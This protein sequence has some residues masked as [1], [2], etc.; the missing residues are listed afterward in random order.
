MA[1]NKTA[2][3]A[4]AGAT[5]TTTMPNGKTLRLGEGQVYETADPAE[6]EHLSSASGVKRAERA[7]AKK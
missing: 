1:T 6:I 5:V 4:H 7:A 3:E 2:F